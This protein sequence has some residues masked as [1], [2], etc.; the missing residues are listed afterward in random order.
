[1]WADVAA[2]G[3][4]KLGIGKGGLGPTEISQNLHLSIWLAKFDILIFEN[5]ILCEF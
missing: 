2:W 4:H 5:S 1:M 3:I